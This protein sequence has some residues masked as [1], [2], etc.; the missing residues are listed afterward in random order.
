MK[1]YVYFISSHLFAFV[2]RL[3]F[4]ISECNSINEYFKLLTS[5]KL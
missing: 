3:K 1:Q 2:S 4:Q 5:G